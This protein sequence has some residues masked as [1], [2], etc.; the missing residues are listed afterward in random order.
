[1]GNGQEKQLITLG[2]GLVGC[3]M[4]LAQRLRLLLPLQI[5]KL[6]QCGQIVRNLGALRNQGLPGILKAC[7]QGG[8]RI[9]QLGIGLHQKIHHVAQFSNVHPESRWSISRNDGLL[10]GT[11][12]T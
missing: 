10:Q 6:V 1:M 9:S 3:E 12:S 8:L 11:Q 2:P 4:Q 7:Q 5:H